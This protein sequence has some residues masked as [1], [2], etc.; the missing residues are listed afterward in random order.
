M[1]PKI[2]SKEFPSSWV[3]ASAVNCYITMVKTGRC[4]HLFWQS[5]FSSLHMEK[6]LLTLP[7]VNWES[8]QTTDQPH[9]SLYSDTAWLFLW[10]F[11]FSFPSFCI[12]KFPLQ[13]LLPLG[14][15][16]SFHFPVCLLFSF[17]SSVLFFSSLL[18]SFHF[19]FSPP[20]LVYLASGELLYFVTCLPQS[21]SIFLSSFPLLHNGSFGF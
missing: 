10:K 13:L 8:E 18:F 20:C 4:C 1:G 21:C 19:C 9:E 11:Y 12:S 2:T 3:T 6:I 14:S 5:D 17:F 7:L 16:L 15:C